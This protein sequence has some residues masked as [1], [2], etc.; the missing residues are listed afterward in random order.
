MFQTRFAVLFLLILPKSTAGMSTAA[1]RAVTT[2]ILRESVWRTAAAQHAEHVHEL[3]RPG[4]SNDALD[5]KHPVYNFF[6]EYYGMKGA[7]GVRKLKQWSLPTYPVFLEGAKLDDLGDLLPLRGASVQSA[8]ISYC[9]SNYYLS[10]EDLVGPASAFVWYYKVLQQSTQRD[11]VLHCY[12]LHEWAM[13]YHPPGSPPPQSGKYQKHLPLR[14]DRDTLN[15]AV[16]RNGVCCT[17]YDALRFFAPTALPLNTVPLVSR[18][19]QLINEQPAC[20]HATMDLFKMI[21]KLQPFISAD[22]KLRCL[23]LAVQARRLDVAA[24]PYD[25][26][27]YGI[28]AI[29]IETSDGRSLYK[30]KQLQLLK[31]SQPVRLELLAAFEQFLQTAFDD[32]TII[33]AQRRMPTSS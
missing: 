21:T 1:H 31:E 9:P 7:K 4:L 23:S 16:E 32:T 6:I 24:S 14:V 2:T 29:P 5:A 11:P 17:H 22:L 19:Q 25:A 28:T 18:D 27:A 12:N 30:K 15:A 33:Q 3:L 8:G 13:Q 26:S 20:L 10:S